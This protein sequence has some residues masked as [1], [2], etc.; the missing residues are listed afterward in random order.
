MGLAGASNAGGP[1]GLDGNMLPVAGS[2]DRELAA[3]AAADVEQRTVRV[4]RRRG[5]G[6]LRV[7][8]EGVRCRRGEQQRA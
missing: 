5:A 1:E 6:S 8:G 2:D 3:G 4:G 7:D